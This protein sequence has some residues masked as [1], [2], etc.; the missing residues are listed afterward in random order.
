MRR[1]QKYTRCLCCTVGMPHLLTTECPASIAREARVACVQHVRPPPSPPPPT[2]TPPPYSDTLQ[3]VG[4]A[5]RGKGRCQ[6]INH[7]PPPPYF[8]HASSE[9]IRRYYGVQAPADNGTQQELLRHSSFIDVDQQLVLEIE[10][11]WH[12][13]FDITNP[14]AIV[15]YCAQECAS[16]ATSAPGVCVS[17]AARLNSAMAQ[18]ILYAVPCSPIVVDVE[19]AAFITFE[20]NA[21][22]P[23]PP[24]PP[25]GVVIRGSGTCNPLPS[26]EACQAIAWSTFQVNIKLIHHVCT[27]KDFGCFSG[28]SFYAEPQKDGFGGTFNSAS[29]GQYNSIDCA[30]AD[31]TYCGCFDAAT[32]TSSPPP[33]P[34]PPKFE[35]GQFVYLQSSRNKSSVPPNAYIRLVSKGRSLNCI[36]PNSRS[37]KPRTLSVLLND[38][39]FDHLK[40]V[41]LS[42]YESGVV[43][44]PQPCQVTQDRKDLV[45]VSTMTYPIWKNYSLHKLTPTQTLPEQ[46][47]ALACA[48]NV[49]GGFALIAAMLSKHNINTR[50]QCS[51]ITMPT[52]R[53]SVDDSIS[54]LLRRFAI[55]PADSKTSVFEVTAALRHLQ[56]ENGEASTLPNIKNHSIASTYTVP[57]HMAEL[58]GTDNITVK[59]FDGKLRIPFGGLVFKVTNLQPS[60]PSYCVLACSVAMA[61]TGQ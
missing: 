50:S 40:Q 25:L 16:R 7:K 28:C 48:G 6:V 38:K 23:F 56:Y 41:S 45:Y 21:R 42:A 43:T 8:A 51:C 26:V 32:Q 34:P 33:P 13:D 19:S 3:H 39:H 20:A 31:A 15:N 61:R 17:F 54:L 5:F 2:A 24:P 29:V 47:C 1:L 55:I 36:P 30:D 14:T 58:H 12:A 52:R 60:E 22:P 53:R 37:T 57:M 59:L 46:Q 9:T 27:M 44:K 18:C 10:G 49:A 35:Q 11:V 4:Y